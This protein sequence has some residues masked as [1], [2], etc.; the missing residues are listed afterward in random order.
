MDE[1]HA[2]LIHCDSW[3][4]LFSGLRGAVVP[5]H[6]G[7]ERASTKAF[8]DGEPSSQKAGGGGRG[9]A[10]VEGRLGSGMRVYDGAA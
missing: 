7:I 10:G 4:P 1:L 2:I 6:S 5:L 8:Q 9:R 3:Q